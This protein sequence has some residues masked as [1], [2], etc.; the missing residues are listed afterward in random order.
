MA[1]DKI[2]FLFHSN[3]C[4]ANSIEKLTE[5]TPKPRSTQ[6][7]NMCSKSIAKTI[8]RVPAPC[9]CVS[10]INYE[11]CLL[12]RLLFRLVFITLSKSFSTELSKKEK[13]RT[14]YILNVLYPACK[15]SGK[16][17]YLRKFVCCQFV[18]IWPIWRAFW[19]TRPFNPLCQFIAF[20]RHSAFLFRW[21]IMTVTCKDS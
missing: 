3:F 20:Y 21:D 9:S 14:L 10:V 11:D 12:G 8:A 6:W 17:L 1:L 13:C 7:A 4:H 18:Y 19:S 15:V 5:D 16:N 2:N